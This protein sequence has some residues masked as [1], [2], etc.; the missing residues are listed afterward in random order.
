MEALKKHS[1]EVIKANQHDSGAY[2]ASPNF[3]NYSF[4]WIRDGSF[5]AYSMLLYGENKSAEKF[6]DWVNS[7]IL[8]NR[9]KVDELK[10]ILQKGEMPLAE[11]Y[12]PTRYTLEGENV[13]DDW[14]N[15]QIDGYGTWLWLLSEYVTLTKDTSIIAKFQISIRTI[16]DYLMLVWDTPNYDCW[17]ENGDR[18]HPSTL[19]CIY[20]GIKG[21]NNFLGEKDLNDFADKIREHVLDKAVV[22]NRFVKYIGSESV[23]SS[24][25]WLS[26]PFG[27]VN[28][29]DE[30]MV[31]TVKLMED[32]IVKSGGV[33][34]FPEDT[35][36]GG[37]EWILLSSWLGWY[38]SKVNNHDK[39]KQVLEWVEK[40]ADEKNNL[41]EQ[42]LYNTN[43]PEYISHWEE[44]W[45]SVAN[46]LLWSHAM[47]LVLLDEVNKK[48]E[49]KSN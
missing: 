44:K 26:V 25:L 46:P 16:I 20:G 47:Y 1:I 32:L 23:D 33:K 15:F 9:T 13:N 8:K 27:V 3:E 48:M 35:Y 45:G 41:P 49:G 12:L 14:P 28:P 29:G 24:L 40:A 43:Y 21:I 7:V 36:Y 38:Y 37:G 2:I 31:N 6:L 22:D 34:R 4:S 11:D 5:I 39:A 30:L 10:T 42:V 18:I 19:A 17:E